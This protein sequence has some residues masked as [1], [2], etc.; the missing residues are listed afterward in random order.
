MDGSNERIAHPFFDGILVLFCRRLNAEEHAGPLEFWQEPNTSIA[1]WHWSLLLNGRKI[2]E[3][4]LSRRTIVQQV[5]AQ[6]LPCSGDALD[7]STS[8]STS[9][10][11]M[12][13]CFAMRVSS[14]LKHVS[15]T[16]TMEFHALRSGPDLQSRPPCST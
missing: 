15:T 11:R 10:V 7:R 5:A 1:R 4:L 9:C 2:S 8:S 6:L 14:A 13:L 3:G 16:G 12:Y